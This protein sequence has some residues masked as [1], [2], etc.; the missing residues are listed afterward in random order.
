MI[1][2]RDC[3]N[4][5]MNCCNKKHKLKFINGCYKCG[6]PYNSKV[7]CYNTTI[8]IEEKRVCP[9]YDVRAFSDPSG[10]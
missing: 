10:S 1:D 6:I 5:I 9:D 2:C 7:Y 3:K 8:G 4:Y